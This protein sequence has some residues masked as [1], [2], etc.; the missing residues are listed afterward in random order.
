MAESVIRQLQASRKFDTLRVPKGYDQNVGVD[1]KFVSEGDPVPP[2]MSSLEAEVLGRAP[3]GKVVEQ[4]GIREPEIVE[5][6]GFDLIARFKKAEDSLGEDKTSLDPL[7]EHVSTVAREM[8]GGDGGS[9]AVSAD[10]AAALLAIKPQTRDMILRRAGNPPEFESLRQSGLADVPKEKKLTNDLA[11]AGGRARV[12]EEEAELARQQSSERLPMIKR[13]SSVMAQPDKMTAGGTLV[14]SSQ[15]YKE[16]KIDDQSPLNEKGPRTIAEERRAQLA[17]E[18][19]A[20][21][22]TDAQI[23]RQIAKRVPDPSTQ[24]LTEGQRRALNDLAGDQ[25]AEAKAVEKKYPE[26]G[27]RLPQQVEPHEAPPVLKRTDATPTRKPTPAQAR[28]LEAAAKGDKTVEELSKAAGVKTETVRR[29]LRSG[30]LDYAGEVRSLPQDQQLWKG[31]DQNYW[32]PQDRRT[33]GPNTA[34][35]VDY[36]NKGQATRALQRLYELTAPETALTE[37]GAPVHLAADNT[38]T[39]DMDAMF[40]WWRMRFADMD[41]SGKIVYPK[42][43]PSAEFI[44]GLIESRLKV[45]DPKFYDRVLPLI[46]RSIEA[47]PDAPNPFTESAGTTAHQ[48]SQ[49]VMLPSPSFQTMMKQAVQERTSTTPVYGPTA[50]DLHMPYPIYGPRAVD[51]PDVEAPER[52]PFKGE[53][54]SDKAKS[55]VQKLRELLGKPG[56]ED[57]GSIYRM[58]ANSPMRALLA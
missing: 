22:K 3:K 13:A 32:E 29:L 48:Y 5:K 49:M 24:K 39:I 55:Q 42:Q 10:V 41:D 58:P 44:T 9:P 53:K 19:R 47:A 34:R 12:R 51:R 1:K 31:T 50:V 38:S 35:T 57:Q 40:P 46:R 36:R 11:L 56:L 20:K 37:Q 43:L 4:V 7:A 17:E 18:L 26:S 15:R 21:G 6:A 45:T 27:A 33:G 14:K 23:E 16:F 8:R 25:I 54:P 2:D 52:H 28:V 30:L